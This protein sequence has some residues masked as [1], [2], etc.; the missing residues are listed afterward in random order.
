MAS[1]AQWERVQNIFSAV[2]ECDAAA[3]STKLDLEC[4]N[5]EALRR[6]LLAMAALDLAMRQDM[7]AFDLDGNQLT[8]GCD[9][10]LEE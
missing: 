5:D 2:I 4:G 8:F 6:E 9:S 1:S 3:R 7:I 10:N